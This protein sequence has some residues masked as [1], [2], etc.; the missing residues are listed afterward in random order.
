MVN[1]QNITIDPLQLPQFRQSELDV[2]VLRLDKIHPGIS[3]NKWFKLKY[4]LE[5][6]RLGKKKRL[7]SFG[8]PYSN[9]IA[10]LAC[11][12]HAGGS[13]STGFIRGDR[14]AI[15]SP[16]LIA[17]QEYG[18][19][20]RFLPR[21]IYPQKNSPTFLSSLRLEFP[22]GLI[23]PEGGSGDAGLRGA[24]E[25]LSAADTSR[26]NQ[27]CCAV[28]TGTTLSGLVNSS[29]PDQQITGISIL[30]GTQDLEPLN[31]S[32]IKDRGDLQKLR[33]NHNYH[34]GGYARKTAGLLDFMNEL[35]AVSGIPTDFVY[36][37][38]LF[39]AVAD[40]AGTG[41]FPKGSRVLIIHSGGIQGNASL[42]ASRLQF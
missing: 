41:Y 38:K 3:G 2:R 37:G 26:Y 34:F 13:S 16:T 30:K 6:A 11:A 7:V 4:Y 15:L 36:T 10:A 27:I 42:P 22:D 35:Y 20:L 24:E 33:I 14:P 23:I 31:P 17:A 19:D 29:P 9:H 1:P 39:Y 12:A 5:E 28:G 25:I 40:L 18:M 8:G 21:D 32:W